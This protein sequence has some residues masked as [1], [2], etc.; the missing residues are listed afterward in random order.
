MTHNDTERSASTIQGECEIRKTAAL[1]E[2]AKTGLIGAKSGWRSGVYMLSGGQRGV[3]TQRSA[4]LLTAALGAA[5]VALAPL[6][7]LAAPG[8]PAAT[9]SNESI[10]P[11]QQVSAVVNVGQA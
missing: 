11:G 6:G 9:D 7:G 4:L 10:A 2:F 1:W 5:M 8:Q 3:M